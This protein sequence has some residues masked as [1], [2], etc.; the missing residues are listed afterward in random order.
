MV[1]LLWLLL[2]LIPWCL[3]KGALRILYGSRA[4]GGYSL[5]DEVLTGWMI[6]IGLAEAAHLTGC[7][8]GQS[9]SDC[10]KLFGIELG[11]C[12]LAA[13]VSILLAWQKEKKN[14]VARRRR[15]AKKVERSL[16]AGPDGKQKLIAV[17]FGLVV[18][19]Q[20]VSVVTGQ[21]VYVGGDMTVETVNSFLETDAVYQVN[22]MTGE[23]YTLGIPLRLK[24]LCL[25]TFYAILC[26]V[27]QL[28]ATRVVWEL[29]PAFVL[30]GSYLS[31]GTVAKK[32][33]AENKKKQ[34][35]FLLAISLLYC[36]GDYLV[37]M[38]GFG[39]LHCGFRGT[40][41]RGA[42]LLPYVM[43]LMLRRKYKLVVLCILAEACIVWTLYG[44]GACLL[45]TVGMA[46]V[47]AGRKLYAKLKGGEEAVL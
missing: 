17:L 22:P 10:I 24:I 33:F 25:P 45:V 41:I 40:T 34:S 37:S 35:V 19:L 4:M 1:L 9:F 27:F 38:D 6:S 3:G 44:M 16:T 29:V 28:P 2:A 26:Q 11:A 36:I 31:Y 18:L 21:S 30:L 43:G 32:L 47:F 39:V 42:I 14:A 12:L 5:A 15:R 20:I 46:A 8:L 7:M 13:V 23:A